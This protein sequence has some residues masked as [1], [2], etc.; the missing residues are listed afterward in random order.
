MSYAQ[1]SYDPLTGVRTLMD[2]DESTSTA[3]FLRQE[4]V[5]P[6]IERAAAN[7]AARGDDAMMKKSEYFCLY[8]SVPPT[9]EH[10]LLKK[11]LNLSRTDDMPK[12]IKE[13]EANYPYLKHTERKLWRPR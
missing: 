3:H 13:I 11:G 10:E 4:D 2:F 5:E 9:I 1:F 8:A 7:R 12:I 6:L